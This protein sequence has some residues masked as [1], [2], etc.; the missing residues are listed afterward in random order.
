MPLLVLE[1]DARSYYRVL[2]LNWSLYIQSSHVVN[3]QN[4]ENKLQERV[5]DRDEMLLSTYQPLFTCRHPRRWCCSNKP[6]NVKPPGSSP[7]AE[8]PLPPPPSPPSHTRPPEAAVAV[9]DQTAPRPWDPSPRSR[10]L[11]CG[12]AAWARLWG[13]VLTCAQWMGT[14][15]ITCCFVSLIVLSLSF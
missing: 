3:L 15:W 6:A 14:E 7:F 12:M 4:G 9:G 2:L 8:A 5:V 10:A 13:S 11:C 1:L